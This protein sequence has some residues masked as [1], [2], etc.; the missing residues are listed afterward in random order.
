[1]RDW[2]L[3]TAINV[4]TFL[5][6]FAWLALAVAVIV[7]LPLAA[8]RKTRHAAGVGLLVVSYIFGATTWF[9]GTAVSFVSFGWIGLIIGLFIFGIGVV[10][11]GIAGA[12]LKLGINDLGLSLCVMLV[13]TL[14]ARFGGA[15]C[16][17]AGERH[18]TRRRASPPQPQKSNADLLGELGR[19]MEQY[20]TAFLDTAQL[21]ASK[22]KLKDVIKEIWRQQPTLR[23]ALSQAY[24]HLSQ[25]QNGI[26]DAVVLDCKLSEDMTAAELSGPKGDNFRQWIEWS[27]ISMAE[28]ETLRQEWENFERSNAVLEAPHDGIRSA[29]QPSSPDRRSLQQP[30]L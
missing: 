10:P 3:E 27:K 14:V 29:G 4:Y 16:A 12:F 30:G 13:I 7:L 2:I 1:M 8:W 11:L 17:A 25:F 18:T 28:L 21:P 5:L 19:L 9:L 15:A 22:Q 20:P 24:L 26:G 6:P 23:A